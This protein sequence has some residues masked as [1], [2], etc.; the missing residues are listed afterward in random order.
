MEVVVKIQELG[1]GGAELIASP[2]KVRV[3]SLKLVVLVLA[4][5]QLGTKVDNLLRVVE[6]L[7]G[8]SL[9]LDVV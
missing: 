6:V 4:C 3:L 7:E 2:L 9:S 1:V 8:D 5:N